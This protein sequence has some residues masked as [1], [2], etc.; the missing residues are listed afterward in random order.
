MSTFLPLGESAF[1]SKRVT[2]SETRPISRAN[3]SGIARAFAEG[4]TGEGSRS[5]SRKLE[6]LRL[7][8]RKTDE[9]EDDKD[10]EVML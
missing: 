6:E 5:S 2:S 7:L 3:G 10:D 9:E 4:A 8:R 1:N